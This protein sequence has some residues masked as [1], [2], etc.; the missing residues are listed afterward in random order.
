MPQTSAGYP[1]SAQLAKL[2]RIQC[3][4]RW[5]C[6][7]MSDKRVRNFQSYAASFILPNIKFPDVDLKLA[8]IIIGLRDSP[9]TRSVLA[10][11]LKQITAVITPHLPLSPPWTR[12]NEN[13]R[14]KFRPW[15]IASNNTTPYITRYG[16]L[17]TSPA[18][19]LTRSSQSSWFAFTKEMLSEVTVM[20]RS[21]WIHQIYRH[22]RSWRV[23]LKICMKIMPK[24]FWMRPPSWRRAPGFLKCIANGEADAFVSRCA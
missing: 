11:F 18:E 13:R 9:H 19:K 10:V 3:F 4:S 2:L 21:S 24:G 12:K 1:Q 8:T 17:D 5:V 23:R 15:S 20:A 6:I 14:P 7:Q 16:L 22:W